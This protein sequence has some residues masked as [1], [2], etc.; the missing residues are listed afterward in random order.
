MRSILPRHVHTRATVAMVPPLRCRVAL[1]QPMAAASAPGLGSPRP[2]LRLDSR[3]SALPH[4][5]RDWAHP[6][7]I[8]TGTGRAP[9]TS[10]PGLGLLVWGQVLACEPEVHQGRQL[11][12]RHE[13]PQE[14]AAHTCH[15]TDRAHLSY[16]LL[17]VTSAGNG[18][19]ALA[20]DQ[21]CAS[22]RPM[23]VSV[24]A[25]VHARV[26]VHVSALLSLF[27]CVRVRACV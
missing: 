18:S 20:A 13:R 4:L 2:H 24:Q 15:A 8:C 21:R 16:S 22:V 11:P 12:R 26:R 10:A 6:C 23:C 7:H 17:A 1:L 27:V 19:V 9:A 3:G 14:H 5:R 25:R